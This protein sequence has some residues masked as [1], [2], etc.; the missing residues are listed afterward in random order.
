VRFF[1]DK[2]ATAAAAPA[3]T[4][5]AD[6]AF[7]EVADSPASTAVQQGDNI[8]GIRGFNWYPLAG[9]GTV[10]LISK[11]LWIMDEY[12]IAVSTFVGLTWIGWV[13][14][15]DAVSQWFVDEAQKNK[16]VAMLA[17][18]IS[19]DT[20]KRHLTV[21][22]FS[23]S[24]G[25]ELRNLYAEEEKVD[26]MAYEY[27]VMKKKLDTKAAMLSKLSTLK[28]LEEDERR[29]A[30]DAL[31]NAAVQYAKDQYAKQPVDIKARSIDW[32]IDNIVARMEPGKKIDVPLRPDDPVRLIFHHF[33]Q[34]KFKPEDLGLESQVKRYLEKEKKADGGH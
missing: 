21:A 18:D 4:S 3:S 33:L 14:L 17:T 19:I 12:L 7:Y 22:S 20:Y 13:S 30:V 25:E 34:S 26:A 32:G 2:P 24:H 1:S 27:Q 29:Q 15:R 6:E 31:T 10:V 28:A 5:T 11:E 23:L 16:D 9:L 8:F